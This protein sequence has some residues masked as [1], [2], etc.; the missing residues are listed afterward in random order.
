MHIANNQGG[1]LVTAFSPA[2]SKSSATTLPGELLDSWG[3]TTFGWEIRVELRCF[4]SSP[5]KKNVEPPPK[6]KLELGCWRF[7][8]EFPDFFFQVPCSVLLGK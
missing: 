1:E 2:T 5:K 6:K 3:E 4:F 8:G 7:G